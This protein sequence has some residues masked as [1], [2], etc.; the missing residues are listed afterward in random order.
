[1]IAEFG[2]AQIEKPKETNKLS[3]GSVSQR[4]VMR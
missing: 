2:K 1:M 4:L 3:E